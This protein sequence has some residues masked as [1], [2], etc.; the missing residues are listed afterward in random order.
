MT[1]STAYRSAAALGVAT[2]LFLL[3]A[4]GALGVIGAEGN[5]TDLMYFGVLAVGAAGTVVARLEPA[6]MARAMTASAVATALVAVIALLG[7]EHRSPVTSV[8]E[9]LGINAMFVTMFLGSAALFQ[10]ATPERS[11]ASDVRTG[12]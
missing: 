1:S 8:A 11:S 10:K 9:I 6:G 12:G 2:A 5:R 7:G 4:I 3:W